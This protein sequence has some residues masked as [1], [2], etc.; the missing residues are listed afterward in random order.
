MAEKKK[1]DLSNSSKKRLRR[2]NRSLHTKRSHADA[3]WES[4]QELI[5]EVYA[6]DPDATFASIAE[7]VGV[8]KARVYQI[9]TGKRSSPKKADVEEEITTEV[10]DL[11]TEVPVS[12]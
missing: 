4:H 2:S 5:R 9:V 12:A 7:V 11:V 3:A 6:E 1:K 10:E 8:T